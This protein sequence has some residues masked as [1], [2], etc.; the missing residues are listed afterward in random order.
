MM[1]VRPVGN[2][3]LVNGLLNLVPSVISLRLGGNVTSIDVHGSN[4]IRRTYDSIS[5][6]GGHANTVEERHRI[7]GTRIGSTVLRQARL[8][9]QSRDKS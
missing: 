6:V 2:I 7:R 1:C 3:P 9:T 8:Q 5:Q 4:L